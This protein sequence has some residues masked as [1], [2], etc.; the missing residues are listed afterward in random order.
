[1]NLSVLGQ[2]WESTAAPTFS[3][4]LVEEGTD[5]AAGH[6][7]VTAE[8]VVVKIRFRLLQGADVVPR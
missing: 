4:S 7:Q 6:N 8:D 5:G 2:G 3:R 1:M